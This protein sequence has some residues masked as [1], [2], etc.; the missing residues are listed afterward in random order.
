MSLAAVFEDVDWDRREPGYMETGVG[1]GRG[2]GELAVWLCSSGSA[3][4]NPFVN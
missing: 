4:E 1:L 3:V 2:A